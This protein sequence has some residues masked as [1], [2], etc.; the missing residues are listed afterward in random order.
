MSGERTTL[1]LDVHAR[2]V[3]AEAVD[4]STGQVFREVL[5][6]DPTTVLGGWPGCRGRWRPPRRPARPG[7]GWPPAAVERFAAGQGR[8]IQVQPVA[9]S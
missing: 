8:K 9:V 5:V 6:P 7:S 4:W 1:G 2:S 3:T